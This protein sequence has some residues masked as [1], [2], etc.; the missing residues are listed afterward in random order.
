[1]SGYPIIYQ[2]VSITPVWLKWRVD[3]LCLDLQQDGIKPG[4]TLITNGS[5]LPTVLLTHAAGQLGCRLASFD[6]NWPEN[7]REGFIAAARSRNPGIPADIRLVLAT[8]GSTGQPKAVLLTQGNLLSSATAV[9]QH[10]DVSARDVWLCCLPLFHIGGLAILHRCAA[11][12]ATLLLHDKFDPIQVLRDIQRY[13][14]TCI[15]LVPS[16]LQRLLDVQ[17]SFPLP[18]SLRIALVGGA[19]LTE[20]L[21]EQAIRAGWPVCP[22][23]GMSETCSMVSV[24]YPP[25]TKWQSGQT[26]QVLGHLQVS[27][28]D[29]Q[30]I[31]VQGSSVM[32]GYSSPEGTFTPHQAATWLETGDTGYRDGNGQ[33]LVQGR[34]DD[35]I[36][37]GGENV[38]PR[39]VEECLLQHPAVTGVM[40]GGKPDEQWGSVLVAAFTGEVG[41]T[42]L[43]SWCRQ[44]LHGAFRPRHFMKLDSL[45][46]NDCH[47]PDYRRLF[48]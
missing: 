9:C 47:K 33:L 26:G 15:S 32:A 23:Y 27:F 43:E 40:V 21:A 2:R 8:S 22:T 46:L 42:E 1:M 17:D 36:I 41:E 4:D 30:R 37:S 3:R 16:M 45:P 10:L 6:P 19:P 38:H 48:A 13:H 11:S 18:K 12:G 14:V 39:R 25:P 5:P 29:R 28:G 31:R 35:I 20:Q 34:L 7:Q 24:C 44:H